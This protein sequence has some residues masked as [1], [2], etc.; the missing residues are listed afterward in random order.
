ML[1]LSGAG[2]ATA[3]ALTGLVL[4][5]TDGRTVLLTLGAGMAA[6]AGLSTAS[7]N[8]RRLG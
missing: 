1:F 2:G 7:H 8:L 6:V 4:E 5:A 3:P